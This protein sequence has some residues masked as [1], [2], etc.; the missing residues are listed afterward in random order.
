MASYTTRVKAD[1][2]R[3]VDEGLIDAAAAEKIARD[4]EARERR[5]LSFGSILAIMAALLFAA[6]I[7]VVVAANWE[8]IPRLTRVVSLFALILAGYVGG[9]LLKNAGHAAIAE[10]LWII[11][12]AAFG[13]SIA[14]IGQMYHMSGDEAGVLLTWGIATGLAA[15]ALRSNPLTIAAVGL[16]AGWM[17]WVGFDFWG[18]ADVPYSY[19]AFAAALWVISLWTGSWASRHLIL[20]SLYLFVFLLAVQNEH[21]AILIAAG[22]AGVSSLVFLAAVF[23]PGPVERITALDG[24]M[25][26]HGL[27]G[28][29]TGMFILHPWL[30]ASG[31]MFIVC[32]LVTLAGI[33]G[34]LML[35]G[36]ES[37]G[38]RW[39]AY[40]GFTLELATV[41]IVL[42]GTM[43][44]TA[45]LFLAAGVA[46]GLVAFVIIRVEKRLNAPAAEG[47][48]A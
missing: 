25:T 28:F 46:L 14:L 29:L 12:A 43:L 37:R 9:A 18:N 24:R 3:W 16:I 44:G 10:G 35:A 36:R 21:L 2:R 1:V 34:A 20:L 27:I 22:L 23:L 32:V 5:S 13:G 41:Y 15:A 47:A 39:I 45:G 8:A 19:L 40:I 4:V 6:A 38:L 7:L 17:F 48:A 31:P 26:V 42:A 33:V 11:A 30:F